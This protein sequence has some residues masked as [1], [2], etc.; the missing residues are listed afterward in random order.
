MIFAKPNRSLVM[1]TIIAFM[2][3]IIILPS[4]SYAQD[5]L[6]DLKKKNDLAITLMYVGLGLVVVAVIFA[7]AKNQT[8]K[9]PDS[10]KKKKEQEKKDEKKE[11]ESDSAKSSLPLQIFRYG[12][13]NHDT[14]TFLQKRGKI[15]F[16]PILGFR[17]DDGLVEPYGKTK[18]TF[19][20]KTI[21]VGLAVNF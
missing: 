11:V 16:N 8:K 21:M 15:S 20:N 3:T 7:V 9:R 6:S 19:S 4:N 1:V 12:Q 13:L 10:D 5:D 18:L 14:N 2:L 17:N